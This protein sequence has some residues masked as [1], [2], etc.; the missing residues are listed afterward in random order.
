MA[1]MTKITNEKLVEV[2]H[3]SVTFGE[4]KHK[5]VA[6]DDVSFDIY[7][8]E[9][10]GLVGESGSGKTTIGRSIIRIH[11]VSQGEIKFHRQIISGNIDKELD[12]ELTGKIQMIFQD[13]MASLN[14]RA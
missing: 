6:V 2:N 10:F 4:R 14:E 13:P 3:I 9:T 1:E 5:F 12:R 11:P 7:K 8:G